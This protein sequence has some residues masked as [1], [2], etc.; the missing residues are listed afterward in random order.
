MSENITFIVILNHLQLIAD[1]NEWPNRVQYNEPCNNVAFFLNSSVW[2]HW[3][4]IINKFN[5]FIICFAWIILKY[6]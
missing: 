6:T 4:E 3:V 2:Y 5:K 1:H